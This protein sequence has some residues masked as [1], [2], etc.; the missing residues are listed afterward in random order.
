MALGS[1]LVITTIL[2][3]ALGPTPAHAQASQLHR[4][5]H[6]WQERLKLQQWKITLAVARQAELGADM[7]GD[8]EYD[9]KTKTALIR[10]LDPSNHPN[11]L[12]K[13]AALDRMRERN[14]A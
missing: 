7:L 14:F 11:K 8:V 4:V 12:G 1:S 13:A 2:L 10:V 9:E 3:M 6:H 5:L